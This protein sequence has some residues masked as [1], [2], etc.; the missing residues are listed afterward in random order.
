MP[1][2]RYASPAGDR[3]GRRPQLDDGEIMSKKLKAAMLL[4][5]ACLLL[6]GCASDPKLGQADTRGFHAAGATVR[7]DY[8]FPADKDSSAKEQAELLGQRVEEVHQL[9]KG[10]GFQPV[11]SGTPAFHIRVV[12]SADK[13]VTG[14]WTGAIAANVV[15]FSFGLVPA[16][17]D[18]RNDFHY[19]LWA[20]QKRVHTIETPADWKKAVG[21]I[22]LSSTVS[23]D[24]SKQKARIGAHDSVIRLWIDQGSFE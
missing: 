2:F 7:V 9:L 24:V 10:H 18:Y 3:A 21:V 23:T 4:A 19:E 11:S 12:E 6:A 17:F 16:M 8:T 22:S 13:D 15:L 5:A 1:P 20:G 14:E